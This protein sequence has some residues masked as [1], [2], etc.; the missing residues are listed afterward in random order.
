MTVT[1]KIAL[2]CAS[3]NYDY[4]NRRDSMMRS[5]AWRERFGLPHRKRDYPDNMLKQLCLCLSDDC[6]RLLLKGDHRRDD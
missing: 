2:R 4:F 5:A 3:A 6:R 1:Q